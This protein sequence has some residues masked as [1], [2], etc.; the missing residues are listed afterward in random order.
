MHYDVRFPLC[1]MFKTLLILDM[2]WPEEEQHFIIFIY[3]CSFSHAAF[4]GSLMEILKKCIDFKGK[5]WT[6][7]VQKA[8]KCTSLIFL[9]PL[10]GPWTSWHTC[11]MFCSSANF[12]YFFQSSTHTPDNKINRKSNIF[13]FLKGGTHHNIFLIIFQWEND[14]VSVCMLVPMGSCPE[15]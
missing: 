5:R 3:T 1:N 15:F 9:G 2:M 10:D 8:V 14:P 12:S 7:A 4:S 6:K 13:F 11:F